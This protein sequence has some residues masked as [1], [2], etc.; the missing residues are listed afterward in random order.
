MVL[1]FSCHGQMMPATSRNVASTSDMTGC[2]DNSDRRGLPNCAHEADQL[3][4][5]S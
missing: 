2:A 1:L 4:L 5:I 3:I